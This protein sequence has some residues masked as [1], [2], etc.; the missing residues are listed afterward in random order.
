L[1]LFTFG[2]W[3]VLLTLAMFVFPK[4]PVLGALLLVGL[5]MNLIPGA[6]FQHS[7]RTLQKVVREPS[8]LRDVYKSWLAARQ[9]EQTAKP[10]DVYIILAEGGGIRA[11]YQTAITLAYLEDLQPGFHKH[12]FAISG[13]SGGSVGAAVFSALCRLHDDDKRHWPK[14][15]TW[16]D[17][18]EH[19]F[20]RDL[21]AAPVGALIGRE[22]FQCLWP[23]GYFGQFWVNSGSGG[24]S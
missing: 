20:S 21:L 2:A 16:E 5:L 18:V 22:V 1:L 3:I 12:V 23:C 10:Y 9:A 13:V 24:R 19:V 17:L 11:A 4:L 15:I 6:S 7:V 14:D 8:E